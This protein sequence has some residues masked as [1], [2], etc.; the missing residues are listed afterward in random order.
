MS[1]KKDKE[2]VFGGDWTEEGLRHF[3]TLKTFDG[4]DKDYNSLI[5][6]YRHMVPAMFK[7]FVELFAEEGHNLQ[8]QNLDGQTALDVIASHPAS[9]AYADI[10][11]A[12]Q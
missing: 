7:D 5:L 12:V 6:A 10:L 3:L 9:V 2:K 4:T 11:R 8:A 1:L